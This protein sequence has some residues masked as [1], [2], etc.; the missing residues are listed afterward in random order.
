MSGTINIKGAII[1]NDYKE[2]YDFFGFDS[3]CPND[4]HNVLNEQAGKDVDVYIN[5]GG[6]SV[7]AGSEIY[8]ALRTYNG[9]VKIHI[10]GLA[11]SAA[12]VIACA[13]ESEMSPAALFMVHNASGEASGDYRTMT[14]AAKNL[15]TV[16]EAIAEA[17]AAK[18]GKSKDELL[19]IMDAETWLTAQQAVE[20]GF[21]DKVSEAASDDVQNIAASIQ[22]GISDRAKAVYERSKAQAA[23]NERLLKAAIKYVE[24]GGKT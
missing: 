24:L 6:G 2:L 7:T 14:Q 23:D 18:T 8:E 17:Y 5:S 1:G 20:Y 13:R 15:Q 22:G 3:T 4:V 9:N 19:E 12:S 10:T 21:V 16:N 11:G